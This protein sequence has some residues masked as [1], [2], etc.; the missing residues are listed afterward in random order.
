MF[1]PVQ[2]IL[3]PV[4]GRGTS[5][6]KMPRGRVLAPILG[7]F[8]QSEKLSG[9]KPP[10]ILSTVSNQILSLVIEKQKWGR[11]FLALC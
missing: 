11:K 9:I 7:N 2:N 6:E 3:G 4:E 8:S 1:G 10:L 5:K